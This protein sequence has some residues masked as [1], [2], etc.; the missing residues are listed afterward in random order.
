M[1]CKYCG[2]EMFKFVNDGGYAWLC[3]GCETKEDFEY[4]DEGEELVP[5]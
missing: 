5:A 4:G 1:K 2:N 3:E